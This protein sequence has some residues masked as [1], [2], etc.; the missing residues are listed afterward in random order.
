MK[1]FMKGSMSS[2]RTYD[3][4]PAG[5][6][7]IRTPFTHSAVSGRMSLSRLVKT[8]NFIAHRGKRF[9]DLAD[10]KVLAAA[11]HTA[12]EAQGGRMLAD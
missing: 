4:G 10:V 3:G 5:T 7:M 9:R 12:E 11:I 6:W 8:F 1:G 2:L